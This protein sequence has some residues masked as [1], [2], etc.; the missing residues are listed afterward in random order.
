MNFFCGWNSRGQ[1]PPTCPP[2][3]F[4]QHKSLDRLLCSSRLWA[5][6]PERAVG[7]ALGALG[8]DSASEFPWR[9]GLRGLGPEG[10]LNHPPGPKSSHLR[11][12]QT[13][14]VLHALMC[15]ERAEPATGSQQLD[16]ALR[17]RCR[18]SE[19]RLQSL[20]LCPVIL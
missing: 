6:V 3:R 16:R 9:Q 8:R 18:I 20:F 1:H 15:A 10:H 13:W 4:S 12:A 7:I 2:E 19:V 17:Y 14:P 11:S 5:E